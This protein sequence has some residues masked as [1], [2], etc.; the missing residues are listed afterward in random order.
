MNLLIFGGTGFVSGRVLQFALDSGHRVVAV[1]RGQRPLPP[2]ANLRHVVADRNEADLDGI[3]AEEDLDAVLDVICQTPAHAEQSIR[4]ARRCKRLLMVSSDYAYDPAFRK[5][6]MT[7]EQARFSERDDYGGNKRRA[8]LVLLEAAKAGHCRPTILRPP[9]IYG[10]GSNP[11]T[12]PQ[13]GRRPNLLDDIDAGKTLSLLHGGL[14]LIQPIHA[15]DLARI[16]LA[17]TAEDRAVGE[18][19]TAAGP[20]LMT[21]LDYYRTM[22]ACIGREITHVAYCPGPDAEDVNHY[23]PGHRYY[24]MGKLN[25]LLPG[26]VYTDF[27]LGMRDWVAHLTSAGTGAD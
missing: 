6:A 14:G 1:S 15:D 12:I 3:A 7:E 20:D 10:P 18:D 24:D 19:Y 27:Q 23:V 2:H 16:I 17:V 4:L 13:H 8:E 25:A 5:L 9:H 21:H 26:F 22:A 11:G